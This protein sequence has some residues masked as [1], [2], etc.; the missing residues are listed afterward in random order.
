MK[1][2]FDRF[3]T[4]TASAGEIGPTLRTPASSRALSGW[5]FRAVIR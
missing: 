2:F 5:R 4:R 1:R 3:R